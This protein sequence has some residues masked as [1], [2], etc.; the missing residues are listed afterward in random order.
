[1]KFRKQYFSLAFLLFLCFLFFIGIY[2]YDNKYQ[3][4]PPYGKNGVIEIKEKDILENNSLFL[5]DGWL[6]SDQD[7]KK[8]PTYIGEYANLQRGN[9]HKTTHGKIS[10]EMSIVYSGTSQTVAIRFPELF[11]D[12]R[13]SLNDE[14]I[15]SGTGNAVVHM[16]LKEGVQTLIVETSSYSGYYSGMYYPP[17]LGLEQTVQNHVN[18]QTFAYAI[19]LI[20]PL[21]LSLFTLLLWRN[22]KDKISLWFGLLCCSFSMYVSYY[23]VHLLSLPFEN[24]WHLVENISLYG[25]M[26]SAITLTYYATGQ[27]RKKWIQRIQMLFILYSIGLFVLCLLI[28]II[29]ETLV[30]HGVFKD[31]YLILGVS[32]I[33]WIIVNNKEINKESYYIL[34]ANL[35]FSIGLIWNLCASNLF[36]PILF[37]WQFEWCG[38]FWVLLFGSMMIVRNKRMLSENER[39]NHH[40]EEEVKQRTEELKLLLDERKMFFSD[41]AHD[42]KAP[43]VSIKLFVDSIIE[44]N[45]HIDTEL[46]Y[47]LNQVEL[48]QKEMTKRVQ[49]LNRINQLDK[50]DEKEEIISI[51]EYLDDI[52]ETYFAETQVASIH[53]SVQVPQEE[54]L[55]VMQR[56]KLDILFENL[57]FN[58]MKATSPNGSIS[59]VALKEKKTLAIEI[60]DTGCGIKKEDIPYIFNRFYMGEEN[61][62]TGSGLGLYIVKNII[63][64]MKGEIQVESVVGKG[65]KFIITI[66]TIQKIIFEE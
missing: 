57:I 37:F 4:P 52:Y 14:V 1:M 20:V 2:Y 46:L 47:Y 45:T 54:V 9:S 41:M 56:T 35:V 10:Y 21:S 11:Q 59:I 24:Q 26:I 50:I 33:G 53:L 30:F 40:L 65:T 5:I 18:I 63:D 32:C 43:L 23:F 38:F 6:M 8:Q 25:M 39:L 64:E 31:I 66:P 27:I 44:H 3:T 58:A 22:S 55:I 42:L 15:T 48:K 7:V 34:L 49:G 36:E 13:I 12:Y 17:E 51:K 16:T 62:K 61:K 28:P 60:S 29:P 19:A